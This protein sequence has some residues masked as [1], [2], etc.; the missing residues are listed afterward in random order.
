MPMEDT[1]ACTFSA[2]QTGNLCWPPAATRLC[3][4]AGDCFP[5]EMCEG[6][7]PSHCDC[8]PDGEPT[9]CTDDCTFFCQPQGTGLGTHVPPPQVSCSINNG[10]C[11]DG[12]LCELEELACLWPPCQTVVRC[13]DESGNTILQTFRGHHG[14]AGSGPWV[15]F[16][17]WKPS[18]SMIASAG[19][20][21]YVKIWEAQT[22]SVQTELHNM[23]NDMGT[24]ESPWHPGGST[25]SGLSERH[26]ATVAGA[27]AIKVWATAENPPA[28]VQEFP[29]QQGAETIAWLVPTDPS[30]CGTMLIVGV[31]STVQ[32]FPIDS[33]CSPWVGQHTQKVS[34]VAVD[35]QGT[36]AVSAS[37]DQTVKI[38]NSMGGSQVGEFTGHTE[39]VEVVRV[40]NERLVASGGG[41]RKVHVYHIDE[42]GLI[43]STFS[44]HQ[45]V[46]LALD[47]NPMQESCL[48]PP[49]G[50]V[51]CVNIASGGKDKMVKLWLAYE[52]APKAV[53]SFSGH[54]GQVQ[55]I[56]WAPDGTKFA[57]ASQDGTVK[58]VQW[59][60]G[61]PNGPPM[62]P[63]PPV[64]SP[65]PPPAPSPP[66]PP[67]GCMDAMEQTCVKD[68]AKLCQ[69]CVNSLGFVLKRAGCTDTDMAEY[70]Q[71]AAPCN[72]AL[73]EAG[74]IKPATSP[75]P[76]T[77]DSCLSCASEKQNTDLKDSQCTFPIVLAECRKLAPNPVGCLEAL[78]TGDCA[79][80]AGQGPSCE[81]C[82]Q[83]ELGTLTAAGC[84]ANVTSTFCGNEVNENCEDVLSENQVSLQ[85][86]SCPN[87]ELQAYCAVPAPPAR[88]TSDCE[89]A[90]IAACQDN[91]DQ[92][93]TAVLCKF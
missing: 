16:V 21:G 72:Q 85:R 19:R 77:T 92:A 11:S 22:G 84:D 37:W 17:E 78:Q 26:V 45:D 4:T 55:W 14:N 62:P 27:Q 2:H 61:W 1:V 36:R 9:S 5:G 49:G 43:R 18:G 71:D 32:A 28:M 65:G 88:T 63:L 64:P 47:W 20:D 67:V 54:T 76:S 73:L 86:A 59:T 25:T 53:R 87:K 41:D 66:L 51:Q 68:N 35:L 6:C 48:S 50:D 23:N 69:Q 31:G 38:W 34:S 10:G 33:S 40:S 57:S 89:Q 70:C 82:I 24:L 60:D 90:L 52:E 75:L 91:S 74:C 8:S 29:A 3:E 58:I 79:Q 93:W 12:E 39:R 83:R 13:Q 30:V 44:E 42:P 46:V 15:N 81:S 56:D 80:F 7:L